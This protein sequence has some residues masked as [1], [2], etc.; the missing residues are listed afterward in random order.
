MNWGGQRLISFHVPPFC[1]WPSQSSA[2]KRLHNPL[3]NGGSLGVIGPFE[4]LM[5]ALDSLPRKNGHQ[6]I[7]HT[8]AVCRFRGSEHAE[9][10]R[11]LLVK[12]LC[13][14]RTLIYKTKNFALN[15]LISTQISIFCIN[16]DNLWWKRSVPC[17]KT[18]RWMPLLLVQC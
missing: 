12:D 2:C 10:Y 13:L 1:R 18:S 8:M 5:K 3:C 17:D 9:T 15:L 16:T 11:K 6:H 7:T 14:I 4:N